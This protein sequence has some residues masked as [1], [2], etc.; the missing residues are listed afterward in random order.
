M[1]HRFLLTLLPA[2]AAPLAAQ[3]A[4]VIGVLATQDTVLI[5]SDSR[6]WNASLHDTRYWGH[7]PGPGQG[8]FAISGFECTDCDAPRR[9]YLLPLLAQNGAQDTSHLSFYY[10]GS[11]RGEADPNGFI[12][13][14]MFL[15]VCT[16][17]PD[18][19]LLILESVL[20]PDHKWSDSTL[21]VRTTHGM[22]VVASIPGRAVAE[23]ASVQ[24]VR[25]K[26]CR[27]IPPIAKQLEG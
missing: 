1:T 15:G 3:R 7:L 27:E 25:A 12:K 4:P 8:L 6:R 26:R 13:S 21:V 18:S 22:P 2:I 9:V 17:Q 24:R 19:V 5:L 14:R 23:S 10:P 16:V 11:V 20:G